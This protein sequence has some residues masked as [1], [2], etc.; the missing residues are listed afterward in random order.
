MLLI[1]A[2]LGNELLPWGKFA[3]DGDLKEA[4]RAINRKLKEQYPKVSNVSIEYY[5]EMGVSR[6][7]V[8]VVEKL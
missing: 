7:Y 1:T 4:R 6:H 3:Y 5:D 2:G 8:V